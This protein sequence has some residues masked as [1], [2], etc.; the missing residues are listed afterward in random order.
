MIDGAHAPLFGAI[1]A[2]G[3]KFVC[4]VGS[5]A[6]GSLESATIPTRDPDAT[7]ADVRAF[8]DRAARH[9]PV[10]AIGIGS[11]GPLQLDPAAADF[12]QILRTPKPGW[13]G[14]DL[15]GRVR[16]FSGV[17]VALDTD[18]NAAAL[19]EAAAAGPNI[20]TLAYV[21]VGTG[22]GVG[23]VI[24]GRP[25]HGLGHPEAGHMLLRR[26]EAHAGFAGI[27]PFHGDCLEGLA[28]GPAVAAHWGASPSSFPDAHP[29]WD[30]EAYYLAQLCA[31]LFLTVA[32]M[33]IVLGGGVM[34]QQAFFARIRARTL[35]LLGGYVGALDDMAAMD[36]RIVPPL[37]AEPPGLI[38]T[39]ILAERIAAGGLPRPAE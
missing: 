24:D 31:T 39:Y 26:H 23:I 5:A 4:G 1:E 28:S 30:M 22:I 14:V 15:P 11:F 18:V 36:K 25:V 13:T 33:R 21:T 16:A 35:H 6:L 10:G 7:F 17:Q 27:C 29:F 20:G 8:F 32:P 9:G 34:K 2:G 38:G 3:T 12:G 19:A 37:C